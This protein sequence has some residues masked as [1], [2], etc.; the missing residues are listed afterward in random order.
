MESDY[1]NTSY[2]RKQ[3]ILSKQNKSNV[4]LSFYFWDIW[5][6]SWR[7]T[8]EFAERSFAEAKVLWGLEDIVINTWHTHTD[9]HT[10]GQFFLELA[11]EAKS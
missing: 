6:E 2:A 9:K 5:D 1:K 8:L 4:V 10:L 3:W 11:S 7:F